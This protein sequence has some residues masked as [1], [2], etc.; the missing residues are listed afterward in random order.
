MVIFILYAILLG[1]LSVYSY[2]L[3][4][5]NITFF[6]NSLWTTFRNNAV[7][8]G[9]H[10]RATSW[11]LFLG[12]VILLFVFHWYCIK[13]AKNVN[14]VKLA[15]LIGGVL[16]F[17]Y[18][19]LSHDFFN[20]MF[21][22]KIL[23]FYHQNP[24]MHK[25]L[26]YPG[27]PWIRFMHW[28][29][30]PYPYGPVFLAV[31]VIPSFLGMGKFVIH[32]FLLKATFV[33]FYLLSV[34]FLA[35]IDRKQA[36]FLA[37]QPLLLIEGL[38]SG[39]NEIVGLGFA[40][41][42]IY[43]I[44]NKP[45]WKGRIMMVLSAAVKYMTGSYLIILNPKVKWSKWVNIA[46]FI[47]TVALILYPSVTVEFQPWYIL[48]LLLFI[49]LYPHFIQRMQIFFA[50][51]ILSY[52]PYVLLGEWDSAY[53]IQLKHQIIWVS[54]GLNLIYLAFVYGKPLLQR[55]SRG[56]ASSSKGHTSGRK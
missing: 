43:Y 13:R 32:F 41:A 29:H 9:Y 40:F 55:S 31:T 3:Q 6:N 4:D 53:K 20:Y 51:L 38:V 56:G 33:G 16:L 11:Y 8:L 34:Y 19:L 54:L 28:V 18:P 23:T 22:A 39:H 26:D 49:P 52:Y 50:G 15:L 27:D 14:P 36:L 46:A 1:A 21:D 44:L 45:D 42:G 2:V 25:A 7:E 5:G 12:I 10:Q 37:T 24:Y 47:G 35:K 48:N 30:R 17:S